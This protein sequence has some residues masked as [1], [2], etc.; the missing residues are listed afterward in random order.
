MAN[1]NVEKQAPVKI[2]E[3]E[4]MTWDELEHTSGQELDNAI[5]YTR[6]ILAPER[7]EKWD[8]YY[9]RN[10]GNEKKGRSQY[11][12]RDL[13]ET[14]EWV[15]PTLI[16]T[17]ASGDPKVKLTIKG[18]EPWVGPA[19]MRKIYEDLSADSQGSLFTVF[20]Q[21]FKDALVSGAAYAKPFWEIEEDQSEETLSA[22]TQEQMDQLAQE[23][24]V[25]V[26]SASVTP[27]IGYSDVKVN[28]R[29][30]R[31]NQLVCENI[32]NWEFVASKRTRNIN[33]EH[34]K[35]QVTYVSMDYLRRVNRA[36]TEQDGEL[37]FVHL[38]EVAAT[39]Q[40]APDEVSS[41]DNLNAERDSYMGYERLNEYDDTETFE[42]GKA[43]VQLAE[44]Y[45]RLDVDGDGFLEDCVV[46][47]ANGK[48]IRYEINEE[49]FVPISAISPIIDCYKLTGLSYADLIIELQNL[50]TVLFRRILDN[51]DYQNAGRWIVRPGAQVDVKALLDNIPGD[52]IRAN[53]QDIQNDAPTPFH[54][55]NLSILEYIDSV[56][57]NRT[58]STRYNQGTDASSLNQ[59]ATGIQMIQSAS[60]QRI[61]Q[62][63][64]IFAE[65]L[66]D[67]YQKSAML[68]QKYSK[69]PFEANVKGQKVVVTNEMLQGEILAR[70]DMGVEAQV[71]QAE[72]AKLE[73]LAG[74]LTMFNQQAP[75]L[76]GPEE[77]HNLAIKYTAAMGYMNTEDFV[78]PADKFAQGLQQQQQQQQAMM[79]MQQQQLAMQQQMDQ[80]K[81]QIDMKE[82][83]LKQMTETGKRQTEL[84][85]IEMDKET[86]QIATA[87]RDRDSIRDHQL[88][89]AQLQEKRNE[90]TRTGRTGGGTS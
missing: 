11:M 58:G 9:G 15:L 17:L 16:R 29:T 45:T 78:A 69:E 90:Q 12:S 56:K 81:I 76:F 85:K 88:G 5:R 67:F 53:P 73:R 51:Y 72:S 28:I 87:Q 20:Y 47:I 48:M 52:V 64:R 25:E 21:W 40:T 71:G 66:K 74:T 68:Y 22:V 38:D 43:I 55:Q 49:G 80:M 30:L 41:A 59:T 37:F 63:A 79:Q 54:P 8:R 6:E 83:E 24:N 10:L 27:G 4:P 84:A 62:V 75:G 39:S 36:R 57:E 34:G 32:P 19:L 65:G 2:P 18:Q 60:M 82:L 14:I 1:E 33:D 61:E 42:G 23:P 31:R 46:W 26:K 70:V 3:L 89:V 77:V 7:M 44:W 50:K 86:T 13:L 35:G